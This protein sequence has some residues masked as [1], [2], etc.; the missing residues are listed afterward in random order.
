M[1]PP[2]DIVEYL[3][4]IHGR[5]AD[6]PRPEEHG[7]NESRPVQETDAARTSFGAMTVVDGH[8]EIVTSPR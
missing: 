4:T 1:A 5:A 7:L 6:A 8:V 2:L 3:E